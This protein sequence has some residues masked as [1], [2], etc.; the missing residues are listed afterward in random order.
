MTA[1]RRRAGSE[2]YLDDTTTTTIVPGVI[3]TTTTSTLTPASQ[4]TQSVGVGSVQWSSSPSDHQAYYKKTDRATPDQTTLPIQQQHPQHHWSS[5]TTTTLPL[6]QHHWSSHTTT[7][8]QQPYYNPQGA[9]NTP[10]QPSATSYTPTDWCGGLTYNPSTSLDDGDMASRDRTQ[11]YARIV[12]S[13]Q[14]SYTNG[15]LP[16]QQQQQQG[17]RPR[18]L[19]QYKDFM[20]R[21]KLIGRNISSTYAKLEKLTHLAKKRSLFDDSSDREIQELTGI[22]RH[23]LT[24]L[25]KQLGDLRNR[26]RVVAPNSNSNINNNIAHLQKHSSNLVGSLQ[27]KVA[28]ITQKFKDILEVRTEN[29]KKQAERRE[30]FTGGVVSG[31][32]PPG[33]VAG[34]HQGSVLLA[35]EAA[36][37]SYAMMS[38]SNHNNQNTHQQQQQQQQNQHESGGKGGEVAINLGN[39]NAYQQQL[40]LMEEQDTYLQSRADTMKTIESTIVEL[41]QMFTQLATMVKEQEELVQSIGANV[42]D[43]EL[44]VEGAH[45]ELLKYFKSVS[46]NRML[47]IKILKQL[48]LLYLERIVF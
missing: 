15:T 24:S 19:R 14:G 13:Q 34:H 10:L 20:Q 9:T 17:K 5:H 16:Q 12:R 31:E 11:E 43:A 4:L 40:Q 45:S 35:A 39:G 36:A 47:M 3:T 21:S 25:T 32:L 8:T 30:Q 23:D 2:S 46:S 18:D 37:E 42:E 29:L 28:F 26:S 48:V 7:T 33:A 27:T 6:Q 44:N 41:G 1:R 22:I 38:P